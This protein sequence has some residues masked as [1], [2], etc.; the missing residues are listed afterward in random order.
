MPYSAGDVKWGEPVLGTP[1]GTI[2]WSQ[3]VTGSID[4]ASGYDAGDISAA[5]MSAFDRWESVASIDFQMVSSGADV[6]VSMA[7][8]SS[9]VAG[10]AG[11][12]FSGTPGLSEIYSGDIEFN[13]DY[14][15]SPYGSGGVDFYAVALH[16]IGHILGLDHVNDTS[17]IMNP[18]IYASD[19][20]SGDIAGVRYLYGTDGGSSDDTD[21]SDVG[22]RG[23]VDDGESDGG[24]GAGAVLG[25]LAGLLALILGV[26]SGGGAAA[27]VVAA[28]RLPEDD[29]P[30]E[31]KGETHFDVSF[32]PTVPVEDY[33]ASA[34]QHDDEDDELEWLI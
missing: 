11:Y 16:E 7:D 25:L 32:L 15:W 22:P 28:A 21:T 31:A 29:D 30:G 10:Q 27:A 5:L 24:G 1:S 3:T 14:T 8:L 26:F 34:H 23:P 6:T 9:G 20:G 33:D 2:T 4:I 18:V 12:T 13:S 19:L 17:E